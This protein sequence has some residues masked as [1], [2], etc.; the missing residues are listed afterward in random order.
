M[1]TQ[2]EV[3]VIIRDLSTVLSLWA[4]NPHNLN[5]DVERAIA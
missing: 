2:R 5:A 3:V 4:M 1:Q